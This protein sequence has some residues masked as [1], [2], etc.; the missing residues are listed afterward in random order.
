MKT[1]SMF[2]F[3][4]HFSFISLAKPTAA[5]SEKSE[6]HD[7]KFENLH[8]EDSVI[9]GFDFLPDQ[10]IIFTRRDGT[11]KIFDPATKSVTNVTGTPKVWAE[12]QGGLLDVRVHPKIQNRI[13]LSYSEL[14]GKEGSTVVAMAT[15][16]NTNLSDLKK[17]FVG[18]NLNDGG[19]HFG[20][21]IE[22]D[23]KGFIYISLGERNVRDKSQQ[24]EFHHGKVLRLKEDGT[25]PTDNPFV[26]NEKAKPEIFSYGHRNPQG[27]A[28]DFKTGTLWAAEM[29]PRGGDEL[30]LIKPGANYGWPIATYG[31]EYYGPKIG[32]G[33][34]KAGVEEPAAY[35]VPSISPS[36]MAVYSGDS[37]PKWKGNIFLGNLSGTHL[38]RIVLDAQN[39]V[40]HQEVLLKD[41]DYRI[42]NVRT[43]LDGNLYIST[44]NGILARLVPGT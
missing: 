32:D 26:K 44:D 22:F 6:A 1:L 35:W 42:R 19:M 7:F 5:T 25:V 40:T 17:I 15:L 21:R 37:F 28:Y 2:L 30:N 24:L 13:Y 39:K 16:K 33:P 36:G 43:G 20:S 27:L 4:L 12:G 31:R 3:A 14:Q 34:K 38:R 10:K 9:W 11:L 23:G 29:G 8:S 18:N 41:K